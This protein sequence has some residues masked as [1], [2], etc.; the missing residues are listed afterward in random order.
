MTKCDPYSG[1]RYGNWQ[2]P[3]PSLNLWENHVHVWRAELDLPISEIEK[4]AQT[5]SP[6]E[7]ERANRFYFERDKKHFIAGRGILRTILGEYLDL[8]PAEIEF[9]YS[10]RGK[11]AI[12][13]VNPDKTLYF[14][15]SHSKGLALYGVS[16]NLNLGIDLE[17][18]RPM[19][20]IEQLAKRFFSSRE[21]TAIATLPDN[22]KE[23][24]FF[25]AWCAKEAYLKATG[26]GLAGGL[27]EVEVSLI[28][29]VAPKFLSIS[30]NSQA[31]LSWSLHP[32]IPAPEYMGALA[33]A[34]HDCTLELIDYPIMANG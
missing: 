34:G 5:L 29:G 32:I 1:L 24:A 22:Q 6:D 7:V 4:L 33:V 28:S 11:P 26:D 13:N 31:A 3:S 8:N 23:A 17:Y 27:A 14:N 12:A 30:G 9:S 25:Q 18:I 21:Y 20:D 19:S 16:R 2:S 15:L 10:P